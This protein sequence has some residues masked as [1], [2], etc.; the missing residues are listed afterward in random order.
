[1]VE[2]GEFSQVKA[3]DRLHSIILRAEALVDDHVD[4]V[5]VLLL[6]EKNAVFHPEFL[7][8]AWTPSQLLSLNL[9]LELFDGAEHFLIGF[10]ILK[11]LLQ[12]FVDVIVDPMP[13]L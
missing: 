8:V 1:M 11:H 13:V 2:P 5:E 6:V 4:E 7:G 10:E 9:V 3:G 12:H